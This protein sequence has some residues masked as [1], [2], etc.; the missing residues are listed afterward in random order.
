MKIKYHLS[1]KTEINQEIT[2]KR[3]ISELDKHGY[4]IIDISE[5]SIA[6]RNKFW[7]LTT[8]GEYFGRVDGGKFI[9]SPEKEG[10]SVNF[11]FYESSWREISLIFFLVISSLIQDYHIAFF[12]P[13]VLILF[14]LRII[15]VKS[16]GN[17]IAENIL[18]QP[19]AP[20]VCTHIF[21][22]AR[23]NY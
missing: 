10:T 12:I 16:A 5:N 6:F 1:Q 23:A 20:V 13:L 8:R 7:L 4:R 18:D 11:H 14:L 17:E 15:N 22:I 3:I 9:I 19:S 2:L 21:G